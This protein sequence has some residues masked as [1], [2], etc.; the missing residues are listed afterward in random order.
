MKNII[1]IAL[2]VLN[3]FLMYNYINNSYSNQVNK[4]FSE[5]KA[6]VFNDLNR[7]GKYDFGEV[8]EDFNGNNK[9]DDA[10]REYVE[11]YEYMTKRFVNGELIEEVVYYNKPYVKEIRKYNNGLKH[12]DW[13]IFYQSNVDSLNPSIKVELKYINDFLVQKIEYFNS[14]QVKQLSWNPDLDSITDII[15]YYPSGQKK[16]EGQKILMESGKDA[17]YGDWIW[18]NESDGSVKDEKTFNQDL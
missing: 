15:N 5:K 6:E 13:T 12:G 10:I 18:Y 14:G 4:T 1:I 9:W 7:N 11:D 3:G 17:W 2:I 16:S 8:F